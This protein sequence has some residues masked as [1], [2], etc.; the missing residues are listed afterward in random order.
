MAEAAD[1]EDEEADDDDMLQDI[2]LAAPLFRGSLSELLAST[3]IKTIILASML[4]ILRVSAVHGSRPRIS[5]REDKKLAF[6]SCR[7]DMVARDRCCVDCLPHYLD[8]RASFPHLFPLRPTRR[9]H[10]RRSACAA[11]RPQGVKKGDVPL[12]A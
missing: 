11:A 6:A 1:D 4:A 2:P 12:S 9:K 5:S 3:E 7:A 8:R 10:R